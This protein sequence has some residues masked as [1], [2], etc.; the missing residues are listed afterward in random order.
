M[1]QCQ[2]GTSYELVS[3]SRRSL[4]FLQRRRLIGGF[5]F[6][7]SIFYDIVGGSLYTKYRKLA[8]FLTIVEVRGFVQLLFLY[9]RPYN[10]D[11]K[12]FPI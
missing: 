2:A 10:D 9:S 6:V 1:V 5:P 4:G 11:R 12:A 3:L 8:T 7:A